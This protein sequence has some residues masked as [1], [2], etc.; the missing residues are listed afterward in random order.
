AESL[1]S[2]G[3]L[4]GRGRPSGRIEA[5]HA[6]TPGSARP[7][8]AGARGRRVRLRRAPPGPVRG[9]RGRDGR[10]A[11]RPLARGGAPLRAG[12]RRAAGCAASRRVAS[13]VTQ[14]AALAGDARPRTLR[15]G[16]IDLPRVGELDVAEETRR[17]LESDVR[18]K[19][20]VEVVLADGASQDATPGTLELS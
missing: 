6:P 19:T 14:P 2:C 1:L 16:R 3:F 4:V 9:D 8:G 11:S 20:P 7:R 12:E 13:E 17:F 10:R 15:I 18:G 5:A